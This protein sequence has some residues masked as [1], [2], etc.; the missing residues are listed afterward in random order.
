[1]T[2]LTLRPCAPEDEG[3]IFD[4]WLR[5]FKASHESGP[6]HPDEYFPAARAALIRVLARPTVQALVAEH[7]VDVDGEMVTVIDGYLVHEPGWK[8]WSKRRRQWEVYAVVH[9]LFVKEEAR[10]KGVACA[11]L[12]AAGVRRNVP[13]TAFSFSMPASRGVLGKLARFVPD[14]ARYESRKEQS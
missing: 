14:A 11:L 1:M 7:A 9:F 6:Y 5:S 4:S 8:R 12:D 10:G 13:S 2:A 3:F